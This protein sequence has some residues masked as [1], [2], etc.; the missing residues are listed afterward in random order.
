[1]RFLFF[2]LFTAHFTV[3]S[4]DEPLSLPAEV[5]GKLS[6]ATQPQLVDGSIGLICV[7]K[8]KKE[9]PRIYNVDTSGKVANYF[10]YAV[11]EWR[12]VERVWINSDKISLGSDIIMADISRINPFMAAKFDIDF[13]YSESVDFEGP[14]SVESVQDLHTLT[15]RELDKLNAKRRF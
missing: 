3:I 8:L 13:N 6:K 12:K 2:L 9:P 7:N 1:M 11:S 15:Q 10:S 5:N 4:A 14:C